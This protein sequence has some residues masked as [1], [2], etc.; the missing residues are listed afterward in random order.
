MLLSTHIVEDI[1][2]TG[3][4]V[5]V[6]GA[7]RLRFTG[8]KTLTAL[9][10]GVVWSV[11]AT[12]PPPGTTVVSALP[13]GARTRYRVLSRTAPAEGARPVEPTIEDGYLALTG[14]LTPRRDVRP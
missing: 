13:E 1:A 9:A 3:P 10:N 14:A 11:T 7:G 8:T 4:Q 12:D 5:G 2:Q 6:L